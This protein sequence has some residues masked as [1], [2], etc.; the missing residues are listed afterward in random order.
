MHTEPGDLLERARRFAMPDG[1]LVCRGFELRQH[2]EI[3]MAPDKPWLPFEAEQWF[4]AA[5]LDFRWTARARLARILPV[6]VLDAFER[7]HGLLSV[8]MAGIV[9]LARAQ[10]PQVDR[11]EVMRALAEMPWRPTGFA[12]APQLVWSAPSPQT[13]RA[14]FDA[15]GIRCY[16]DFEVDAE[17]RVLSSGAP[18]RPRTLGKAS[19]STP[20]RGTFAEYKSFDGLRVPT[21]A[22]VAWLQPD[23]PFTYFRGVVSHFRVVR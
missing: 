3:R 1:P 9:P 11:G 17:G 10:G 12:E 4:D 23:G 15:G 14:G 13:L 19:V 6:K 7:G 18:D 21:R 8:R 2:G 20:W 16:V 22:G 5:G